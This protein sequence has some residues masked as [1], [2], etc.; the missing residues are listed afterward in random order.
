MAREAEVGDLEHGQGLNTNRLDERVLA[1]SEWYILWS[2]LCHERG[3]RVKQQI[4]W[5]DVAVYQIP[6]PEI[7]KGTSDLLQEVAD[8]NL[9]NT[10]GGWVGI[11]P[12][13]VCGLW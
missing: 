2:L 6:I 8:Q 5:L 7:L 11:S 4:L 3:R 10:S 13:D 9:M 1:R 12:E